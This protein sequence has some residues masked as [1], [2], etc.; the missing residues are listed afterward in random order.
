MELFHSFRSAL[1]EKARPEGDIKVV[2]ALKDI[3]MAIDTEVSGYK[4]LRGGVWQVKLLPKNPTDVYDRKRAL[5]DMAK[6][7][8]IDVIT[9]DW[10]SECNMTLRGSDKRDRIAQNNMSSGST[11]VAKGYEPYFLEEMDPAI[12]WLAKKGVKV[13]MNADVSDVRGLAEALKELIKK[14]G[15]D[16]KIGV[17]DGYDVTDAA[18]EVYRQGEPFFVLPANK[19]IEEWGSEPICA[20]CYLGGTGITACFQGGAGVVLCGRVADA[21]VT[22]GVAMWWHGWTRDNLEELAGAL[23]IGHII[24]C[25]TYA[26]GGFYSGF[27]DLGVNDTDMGCALQ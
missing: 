1:A 12:P 6:N 25:S 16:L 17:V 10:M 4:K 9:G 11:V 20:Q 18:L 24:E 15:V 19:P 23:M 14:H 26:T 8:D 21:S 3:Q 7:D 2:R 27:R 5:H 13:A 22:V